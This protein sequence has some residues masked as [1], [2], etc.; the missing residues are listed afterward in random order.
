MR[1]LMTC[2]SFS[3]TTDLGD[4]AS[5]NPRRLCRQGAGW[6]LGLLCFTL[7]LGVPTTG[8]AQSGGDGANATGKGGLPRGQMMAVLRIAQ[9]LDLDDAQAIRMAGKFRE[10]HAR[11]R[12]LRRERKAGIAELK[13]ELERSPS[14]PAKL[15]SLTR[16]LTEVRREIA[17]GPERLFTEVGTMLTSEQRAKL[18]IITDRLRNQVEREKQRRGDKRASRKAAKQKARQKAER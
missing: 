6:L 18:A 16:K 3:G 14:D 12:R 15:D 11:G 2:T 8:Y 4:R 7:V 17:L 9:Q 10:A 1:N 5:M 13:L